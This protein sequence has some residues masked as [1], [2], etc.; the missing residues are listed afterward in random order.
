MFIRGC[1]DSRVQIWALTKPL[2]GR[3]K[4]GK[5]VNMYANEVKNHVM[6]LS[7]SEN[8]NANWK[9]LKYA[10]LKVGYECFSPRLG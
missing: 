6:N 10:I 3:R 9:Q 2:G 1:H 8:V 7:P 5:R 4:G